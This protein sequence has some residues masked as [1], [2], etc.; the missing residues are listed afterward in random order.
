MFVCAC[1]LVKT[2]K[3]RNPTM[4]RST[5]HDPSFWNRN[6]HMCQHLVYW[7]LNM[8]RYLWSQ[9]N[10]NA[11]ISPYIRRKRCAY[12]LALLLMRIINMT[13]PFH[14]HRNNTCS[15]N[16]PN[17]NYD[18]NL[19]ETF[20]IYIHTYIYIYIYIYLYICMYVFSNKYHLLFA[21]DAT[22]PGISLHNT[23]PIF[24]L[25][26]LQK[27]ESIFNRTI[28]RIWHHFPLKNIQL[29]RVW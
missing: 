6:V 23:G 1:V 13:L 27:V 15:T 19:F 29:I 21:D 24:N 22:A 10:P 26:E 11:F 20:L 14:L 17:S 25:A 12:L 16:T 28:G 2:T 18:I 3:F 4:Q 9:I 8:N 5:Y 7:Y